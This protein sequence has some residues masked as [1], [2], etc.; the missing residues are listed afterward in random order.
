MWFIFSLIAL[1][2]W[3]G[4]D[5]FSK[6]GTSN[7]DKQSHWKVVFAVGL[8]MGIHFIITLIGGAFIEEPEA[9]PKFISSLF[10]TDFTM[11][12]FIIY[13]HVAAIYIAD[14]VFGYIGLRFIELSISIIIFFS[15]RFSFCSF[16]S[17]LKT[18]VKFYLTQLFL[19]LLFQVLCESICIT[20]CFS[21]YTHTH[22][23]VSTPS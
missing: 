3:S 19:N 5:L 4:S 18:I 1:L 13:L 2:C 6:T 15:L 16:Y 8:V 9:V 7:N 14:M 22:M 21:W 11:H 10:Y 20:Y 23:S 17:Y 12:D